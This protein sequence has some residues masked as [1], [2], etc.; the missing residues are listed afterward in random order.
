[1]NKI[2]FKII[3]LPENLI[4]MNGLDITSVSGFAII[5]SIVLVAVIIYTII[6]L[7]KQVRKAEDD[8]KK[9]SGHADS[10]K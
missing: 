6:K 8:E 3:L 5:M 10:Q 1:L 7:K 4:P 9:K 2:F